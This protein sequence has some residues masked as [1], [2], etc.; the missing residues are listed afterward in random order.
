MVVFRLDNE[1]VPNPLNWDSL[2]LNITRDQQL[3]IL[4]SELSGEMQFNGK[5]FELI[6]GKRNN[7]CELLP[8]EVIIS[9]NSQ[10]YVFNGNIV[11]ADAKFDLLRCIATV[12]LVDDGYQARINNNKNIEVSVQNP[13]LKNFGPSGPLIQQFDLDVNVLN[14]GLP[15][16]FYPCFKLVDVIAFV[17]KVISNNTVTFQSDYLTTGAGR[18]I[19]LTNTNSILNFD[20]ANIGANE[21]NA[22]MSQALR[23]EI[24]TTFEK[25]FTIFRKK[26]NL[27]A[28][29]IGN[30]LRIEDADFFYNQTELISL[31][32]IRE[33]EQS[34]NRDELFASADFGSD[35]YL[36]QWECTD[37]LCRNPQLDLFGHRAEN[38]WKEG[39]CNIDVKRD[40]ATSDFVFDTNLLEDI[41][42]RGNTSHQNKIAVFKSFFAPSFNRFVAEFGNPLVGQTSNYYNYFFVNRQVMF[43][44]FT[45][46]LQSAIETVILPEQAVSNTDA[47][48]SAELTTAQTLKVMTMDNLLPFPFVSAFETFGQYHPFAD[49]VNNPSGS[50]VPSDFTYRV[51]ATG[52]YNIRVR[53]R[54]NDI[55]LSNPITLGQ[56]AAALLRF[57]KFNGFDG[58]IATNVQ[59]VIWG[60]LSGGNVFHEINT[61]QYLEKGSYIAV[62]YFARQAVASVTPCRVNTNVNA[63]VTFTPAFEV[64]G[65]VKEPL[66]NDTT[67]ASYANEQEV[68]YKFDESINFNQA[69]SLISQ[70]EKA[71]RITGSGLDSAK[72]CYI[73]SVQITS[74]KTLNATFE[75]MTKL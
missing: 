10:S 1:A 6:Y 69:L 32:N 11:I 22:F 4:F 37:S 59:N 7:F 35:P 29:F 58:F 36:E 63:S 18:D 44:H 3:G 27:Q 33:I 54:V 71:I 42:L 23:P 46:N 39:D 56:S 57:N 65:V 26:A 62:D 45:G 20:K 67:P 8:Y 68:V 64:I 21:I 19:V 30:V 31:N 13:I 66:F 38:Y 24:K 70:P 55:G 2:G 16:R 75:L 14:Y 52:L 51:P 74:F 34:Y 43:R 73:K 47:L 5:G 72:K 12:A 61:L 9:C 15:Q 28:W 40:L 17:V 48:F 25:L 49:V 53:V 41:I 50:Y 60:N